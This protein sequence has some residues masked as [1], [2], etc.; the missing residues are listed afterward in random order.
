[1]QH[2]CCVI[3]ETWL[4]DVVYS[5]VVRWQSW[6]NYFVPQKAAKWVIA[7]L[8]WIMRGTNITYFT[9]WDI[10]AEPRGEWW[11]LPLICLGKGLCSPKI[12]QYG[13]FQANHIFC[14]LEMHTGKF[15]S[16]IGLIYKTLPGRSL[17]D[18]LSGD[19]LL[20]F[21]LYFAPAT[22]QNPTCVPA[23]KFL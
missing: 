23:P 22:F 4:I 12:I 13:I 16:L 21:Q 11:H 6:I 2:T 1:M 10:G 17:H 8:Y 14:A 9:D 5:S 7:L 18:L 15:S 19:Q 3:Q 20:L